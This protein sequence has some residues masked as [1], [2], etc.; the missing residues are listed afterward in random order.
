MYDAVL[1]K[2]NVEPVQWLCAGSAWSPEDTLA[3]MALPAG[4]PGVRAGTRTV[5]L[6]CTCPLQLIQGSVNS[7]TDCGSVALWAVS[8]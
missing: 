5:K 1:L 3:N 6:G 2:C 8:R 7:G 4:L